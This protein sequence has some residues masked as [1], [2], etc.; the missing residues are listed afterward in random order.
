MWSRWAPQLRLQLQLAPCPVCQRPPAVTQWHRQGCGRCMAGIQNQPMVER[1]Q[2]LS[3]CLKSVY[4]I[5]LHA[6]VEINRWISSFSFLGPVIICGM[7][8]Q[9]N[10]NSGSDNAQERA[11]KTSCTDTSTRTFS[12]CKNLCLDSVLS[13]GC[14]LHVLLA[15]NAFFPLPVFVQSFFLKAV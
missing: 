10:Y 8:C 9:L 14:C 1:C 11:W 6:D 2:D 3:W 12:S 15:S 5:H 4:E 7:I 13:W